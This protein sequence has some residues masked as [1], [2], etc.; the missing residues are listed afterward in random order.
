MCSERALHSAGALAF[1]ELPRTGAAPRPGG[2]GQGIGRE[3]G[4][5][6]HLT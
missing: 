2:G 3:P 6:I 1:H 5:G 4:S